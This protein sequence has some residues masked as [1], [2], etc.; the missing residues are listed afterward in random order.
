VIGP[1]GPPGA[2]GA[3]GPVG[4]QGPAGPQG[5]PGTTAAPSDYS[6]YYGT[7][8][9]AGVGAIEVGGS[10]DRDQIDMSNAT[11]VRFVLTMGAL[12]LP[13]GS[14]AQAQYTADGTNW[15]TLSG[16]VP[17]TTPKGIFSSGW[18]GMPNGANSDYVV[19]IVVFNAGT[20]A[21]QIGLRQLHL[22]FK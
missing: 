21:A 2:V 17:V 18:Q 10:F 13:S 6:F 1:V 22:Q 12:A 4:V 8:Y 15:Y 5:P 14:Y 11:S 3:A 9:K 7:G 20:V 19:R 16:E